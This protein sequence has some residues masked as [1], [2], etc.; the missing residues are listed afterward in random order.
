MA[1]PPRIVVPGLNRG[2]GVPAGYILGRS[3]SGRGPVELLRPQDIR[4][5]RIG[6]GGGGGVVPPPTPAW[7]FDP[8]LA[9][10]FPF[11]ISGDATVPAISDDADVGLKVDTGT[12][13]GG[14]I[15]R[16]AMKTLPA[17]AAWTVT[18][19]LRL[20]VTPF[21]VSTQHLLLRETSTNK[22]TLFGLA[23]IS[24]TGQLFYSRGT[25]LV[26]G[27]A[28]VI[29]PE[30][31]P[32]LHQWFRLEYVPG[33]NLIIASFSVDGK[34]WQPYFSDPVGTS[35]TTRPNQI[36]LGSWS[37]AASTRRSMLSCPYW[38]QTF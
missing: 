1:K 16:A 7:D 12:L 15:H 33:S 8:P 19:K 21:A 30:I 36:G 29:P 2:Q 10:D 31:W 6:G 20:D 13:P 14:N 26:G 35:F 11:L 17:S 34:Q 27:I 3:S 28:T 24:G 38:T 25:G 9:V 22:M 23:Q 32:L 37:N 4:A 18:A 5:M